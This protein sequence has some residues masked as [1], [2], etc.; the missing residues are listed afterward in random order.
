MPILT[1]SVYI[2]FIGWIKPACDA[3]TTDGAVPVAAIGHKSGRILIPD[4]DMGRVLRRDVD[5]V[6]GS[7]N[8]AVA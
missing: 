3:I 7:H 4:N 6:A 2:V 8:Q 5:A 1:T